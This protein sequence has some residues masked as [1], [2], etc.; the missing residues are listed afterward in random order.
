MM[1]RTF[2]SSGVFWEIIFSFRTAS[3]ACFKIC[4]YVHD[5]FSSW[6]H[7]FG[8]LKRLINGLI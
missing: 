5:Y 2:I 8:Y 3:S 6:I 4:F 1:A 7:S